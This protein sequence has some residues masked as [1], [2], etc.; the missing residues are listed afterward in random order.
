MRAAEIEAVPGGGGVGRCRG[1]IF[2]RVGASTDHAL[3]CEQGEGTAAGALEAIGDEVVATVIS[4]RIVAVG[5]VA[6]AAG[7]EGI[8]LLGIA[9]GAAAAGAT[10]P[11]TSAAT[12]GGA[13]ADTDACAG[14]LDV[15][16][17]VAVEAFLGRAFRGVGEDGAVA[18]GDGSRGAGVAVHGVVA[19]A[20]AHGDAAIEDDLACGVDAIVVA[21]E[22]VLSAVNIHA[23]LGLQALG[24]VGAG[25]YL[26]GTAVEGDGADGLD[27]F[28]EAVT[29]GSRSGDLQRGAAAIGEALRVGAGDIGPCAAAAHAATARTTT[30]AATGTSAATAAAAAGL[31]AVAGFDALTA[32][33]AHGDGDSA[34]VEGDVVTLDALGTLVVAVDRNNAGTVGDGD[35]A[36]IGLDPVTRDAAA[37]RAFDGSA[38]G[39]AVDE[40]GITLEGCHIGGVCAVAGIDTAAGVERQRAVCD[41]QLAVALDTFGAGGCCGDVECATLDVD[42]TAVFVL[43][44]GGLTCRGV[45]VE[46][47]LQ[48]VAAYAAD[49]QRAAGH[50]EELVA[51]DTVLDS[52]QDVDGAVADGHIIATPDAVGALAVAADVQRALA[53][54]LTMSLAHKGCLLVVLRAVGEGVLGVSFHADIDALA[55]LDVEGCTGGIGEREAAQLHGGFVGAGHIELAVAAVAGEAVGDLAGGVVAD[56]AALCY[57]DMRA[58]DR[59][60]QIA[61][62]AAV[63]NHGGGI[64]VVG[65]HHGGVSHRRI[66]NVHARDGI[67]VIGIT[68][69][70]DL[71]AVGIDHLASILGRNLISH[72][73]HLHVQRLRHGGHGGHDG[74]EGS[75][76]ALHRTMILEVEPSALRTT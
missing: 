34:G 50:L 30:G 41:A 65:D 42:V 17:I 57:A 46:A 3:G 40:H 74:K 7:H 23:R 32:G 45:A 72:A 15:A 6:D 44:V 49:S 52:L 61:G 56:I 31:G 11:A 54:E 59:D 2:H 12:L 33:P 71:I 35:G 39:A 76:E 69:D 13:G 48:A 24:L 63:D 75:E 4:Q 9:D 51:V 67:D 43:M 20:I 64:A 25:V 60:R 22:V 29:V 10:A 18:D 66:I 70:G 5:S 14:N 37:G 55:I 19:I 47:A 53:L 8:A 28:G 21:L 27:A 73:A 62:N 68:S 1:A 26:S 58:I 38:D 16:V 36:A